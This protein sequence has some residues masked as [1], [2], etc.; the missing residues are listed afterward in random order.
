MAAAAARSLVADPL[1]IPPATRSFSPPDIDEEAAER[2]VR[3]CNT[4]SRWWVYVRNISQSTLAQEGSKKNDVG[5]GD[6]GEEEEEEDSSLASP[7][8]AFRGLSFGFWWWSL[9]SGGGGDSRERGASSPAR[10][11]GGEA[12]SH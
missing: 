5:S 7:F 4:R 8:S 12:V 6:K 10:V 2:V 11:E 3:G 9:W 1:G